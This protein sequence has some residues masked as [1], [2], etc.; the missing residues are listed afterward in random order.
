MLAQTLQKAPTLKDIAFDCFQAVKT[1]VVGGSV[2]AGTRVMYAVVGE[3]QI[4]GAMV[5]IGFMVG[6][7]TILKLCLELPPAYDKF[8]AWRRNRNER[9]QAGP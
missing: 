7:L 9:N 5:Y 3:P 1:T 6:L 2:M 4:R 8:Q